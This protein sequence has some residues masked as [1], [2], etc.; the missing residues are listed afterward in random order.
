LGVGYL[1]IAN[2]GRK[3]KSIPSFFGSRSRKLAYGRP[4]FFRGKLNSKVVA[5]GDDPST[6]HW[7]NLSHR[8]ALIIRLSDRHVLRQEKILGAGRLYPDQLKIV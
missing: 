6:T 4:Q 8:L 3:L 5:L 2:V 1:P 7:K